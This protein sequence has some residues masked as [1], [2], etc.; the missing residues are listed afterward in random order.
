MSFS[1]P[2]PGIRTTQGHASVGRGLE[3]VASLSRIGAVAA[4]LT[5]KSRRREGV[6]DLLELVVIGC[7]VS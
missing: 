1:S 4:N 3:R 5:T 2:V 6:G 7:P